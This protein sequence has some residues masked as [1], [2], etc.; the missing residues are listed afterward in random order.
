MDFSYLLFLRQIEISISLPNMFFCR[1]WPPTHNTILCGF[2]SWLNY[3]AYKKADDV[4]DSELCEM[5]EG[6][7]WWSYKDITETVDS[8]KRENFMTLLP[9]KS[10]TLAFSFLFN[11][12]DILTNPQM[13]YNTLSN[14]RAAA[15]AVIRNDKLS[16]SMCVCYRKY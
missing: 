6:G 2:L 13:T 10:S 1:L 16:G 14:L 7:V 5:L 8:F 4:T 11:L 12:N 15:T 3:R 9:K